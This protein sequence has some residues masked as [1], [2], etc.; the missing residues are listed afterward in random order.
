[1]TTYLPLS[2]ALDIMQLLAGARDGL[3]VSAISKELRL[4]KSA[5]HRLLGTML[6][7]G[8]VRQ[9]AISERYHL[10][11]RLAALGFRYLAANGLTDVVQPILNRLAAQTGELV[12]LGVVD[13]E[14]MF[15][16]A[17]AQGSV[18]PLRYVP[19][20]GREVVLHTTGS[21]AT[22]LA[23][24]PDEEAIRILRRH[25]FRKSPTPGYGRNAVRTEKEFIAKIRKVRR[26]GFA[27]NIEEG[28]PFI[29]AIA[30]AFQ[31]APSPSSPVAGTVA[32]AGPSNRM[33]RTALLAMLPELRAHCRELTEV[34][35]MHVQLSTVA[36]AASRD[37]RAPPAASGPAAR[38][39]RQTQAGAR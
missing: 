19:V 5:A 7:D 8:Y 17:W 32:I 27:L 16:V 39:E 36:G 31:A 24:L 26:D 18:S 34:W 14:R 20:I 29:N 4:A 9:D 12:H 2:R 38:R 37:G 13:D 28:E 1:M 3:T 11:L 25:G 35:P 33:T 15:W 6:S 21:G 23:S 30:V 10:T 22:W